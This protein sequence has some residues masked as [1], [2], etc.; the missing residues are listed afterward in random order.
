MQIQITADDIFA[1]Y[2]AQVAELNHELILERMKSRKL[3]AAFHQLQ[4]QMPQQNPPR[5]LQT[6]QEML[7]GIPAPPTPPMPAAAVQE[8]QNGQHA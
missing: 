4:A 7:P 6:P 3:E 2:K 8:A 1:E 5:A